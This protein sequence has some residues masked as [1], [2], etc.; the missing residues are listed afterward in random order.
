[1]SVYSL[2]R[3]LVLLGT[4]LALAVLELFHPT[5]STGNAL[6]D[7][8]HRLPIWMAVHLLQLPLFGLMALAVSFLLGSARGVVATAGRIALW[9]FLVFYIAFDT[10][11]GVAAGL[12]LGSAAG[13]SPEY[14]QGILRLFESFNFSPIVLVINA[15]GALGWVVSVIGAAY[16]VRQSGAPRF[17][18]ICLLLSTMFAMHAPP[19]GPLGLMF[20]LVAAA[21]IE[22]SQQRL[23]TRVPIAAVPT[24]K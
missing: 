14:Q 6:T 4:P 24:Y 1:M 20:F 11:A 2:F 17:A 7:L 18:I 9:F 5:A 13:Q 23:K 12:A 21:G 10:L 16:V 8:G 15:L 19:T 22:F 3:R